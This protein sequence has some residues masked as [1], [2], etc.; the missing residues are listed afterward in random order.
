MEAMVAILLLAQA[1][2]REASMVALVVL[3]V[4]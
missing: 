2:I 3:L 1:N 4:E